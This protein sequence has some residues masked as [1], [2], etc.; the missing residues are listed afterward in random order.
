MRYTIIGLTLATFFG[1]FFGTEGRMESELFDFIFWG[2]I[3]TG[4]L[5]NFLVIVADWLCQSCKC[6]FCTAT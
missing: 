2:L 4:A 6:F 5:M 1:M 3:G